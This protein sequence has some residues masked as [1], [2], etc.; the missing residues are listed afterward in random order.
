MFYIEA[1]TV[2]AIGG[3]ILI[4]EIQE[5]SNLTYRLYD[6]NRVGKDGKLR[7]LHIEKALDVMNLVSSS[8]PRQPMRKLQY[9]QGSA[10][11]LLSRCKYFQ[12]ERML[13]NTE[14]IRSMAD[15]QSG[16]TSFEVLLCIDG[17][18]IMLGEDVSINIFRGDCIFVPANSEKLKIHGKAE[19]LRIS[20]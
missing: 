11:E 8:E 14:R 5:S 10:Y 13:V 17:C 9:K 4:A 18:G 3:G 2:H 7:E 6:Y 20:C 16:G 15:Y 12:V 19:F 1:G